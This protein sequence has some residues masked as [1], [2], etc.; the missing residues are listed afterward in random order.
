MSFIDAAWAF[1]GNLLNFVY[2]F[3]QKRQI[4]DLFISLW[5]KV[6]EHNFVFTHYLFFFIAELREEAIQKISEASFIFITGQSIMINS[7]I[8]VVPKFQCI[9]SP[10]SIFWWCAADSLENFPDISEVEIIMRVFVWSF[11]VTSG[12]FINWQ[13][14]F[15]HLWMDIFH[16]FTKVSME[17]RKELTENIAHGF[18]TEL[19]IS[20]HIEV[21]N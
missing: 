10:A 13:T 15:D 18:S 5:G 8:L 7:H 11:E 9:F 21:S 1:L 6:F 16:F 14:G 4:F 2:L 3:S 19:G 12:L 17:V 20:H